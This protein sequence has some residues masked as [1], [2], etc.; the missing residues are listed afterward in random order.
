M[1]RRDNTGKGVG[2]RNPGE[3][4]G[5]SLLTQQLA[6]LKRTLL[7]KVKDTVINVDDNEEDAVAGGGDGDMDL[8]LKLQDKKRQ[9]EKEGEE[10][11]KGK[12][13]EEEES[14]RRQRR[15]FEFGFRKQ[16]GKR[17]GELNV[18]QSVGARAEEESR[19]TRSCSSNA[20]ET[21][22]RNTGS[23]STGGHGGEQGYHQRG[24]A[25]LLLFP[26]V[27]AVLLNSKQRYEGALS[28][29][30][31]CGSTSFRTTRPSR[32]PSGIEV[33]RDTLRY[34]GGHMEECSVYLEL[35]PLDAPNSAP[36]P[37]LLEAKR[38]AK[39]IYK[40]QNHDGQRRWNDW[41]WKGEENPK[42]KGKG[43]G[44]KGKG[45]WRSGNGSGD[46]GNWQRGSWWDA[47]RDKKDG[48]DGK[49][50]GGDSKEKK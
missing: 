49:D 1:R 29:G 20:G 7:A 46:W 2:D 41:E 42:R 12:R 47:N 36:T 44:K 18:K 5:H 19:R 30:E 11:E 3:A 4:P 33:F 16:Q 10:G 26:D 31:L 27:E 48:K 21:C 14:G 25:E 23:I 38:H 39:L 34:G 22:Q 15:L 9:K 13:K 32:R 40:S 24:E 50:S 45:K 17:V 28:S 8:G 37:I 6:G 43:K 35:N